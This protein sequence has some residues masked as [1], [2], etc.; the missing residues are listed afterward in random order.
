MSHVRT[1]VYYATFIKPILSVTFCKD[2]KQ[3]ISD[4]NLHVTIINYKVISLT[5]LKTRCFHV[6]TLFVCN[7]SYTKN[8]FFV[9]SPINNSE[10]SSTHLK[11]AQKPNNTLSTR[12][13]TYC[14]LLVTYHKIDKENLT[15]TNLDSINLEPYTPWRSPIS[16]PLLLNFF[17]VTACA[18]FTNM[19]SIS[20]S[21][22][23]RKSK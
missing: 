10:L 6:A 1:S 18:I 15:W 21:T 20:T 19:L 2:C 12:E 17:F 5:T 22:T 14:C 11:E 13:V 4:N 8:C 16:S 23:L 9:I 7:E 3:G